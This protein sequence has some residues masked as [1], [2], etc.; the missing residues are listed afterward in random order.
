MLTYEPLSVENVAGVAALE[1]ECFGR[2]AWSENLLRAEIGEDAKHY[3]VVKD[4]EKVVAYGGFSQVLDE[5][6]VMN[7][8]VAESYRR[9]GV[10]TAVLECFFDMAKELGVSAF[11]LEVRISNR[12]AR[13]LYEKN[14][15]RFVGVRKNYYSDGEDACIYWKYM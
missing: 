3:V 9:R 15:F 13:D 2:H 1:I 12:P 4:G 7:I 5:G 14:G 8:C 10:A 11:T 6:D